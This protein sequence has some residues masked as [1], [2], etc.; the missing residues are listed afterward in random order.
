MSLL[1]QVRTKLAELEYELV[2]VLIVPEREMDHALIL[3]RRL[4]GASHAVWRAASE[5]GEWRGMTGGQYDMSLEE[6]EAHFRR[7]AARSSPFTMV[8]GEREPTRQHALDLLLVPPVRWETLAE[9]SPA[10]S[11][12]WRHLVLALDN[13]AV[14]AIRL[15]RYLGERCVN[16]T[17]DEA[18][19]RQNKLAV[20]IRK[21]LG[22]N[23]TLD[24]R[25]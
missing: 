6:A 22:Y 12:D 8:L 2:R 23:T 25:F 1:D 3:A 14:G 24:L 9:T 13:I 10:G 17:H 20:K 16:A 19:A 18:A 11:P 15:S 4:D 7:R 21:V 5:Q